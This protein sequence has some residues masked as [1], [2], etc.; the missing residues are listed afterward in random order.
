MIKASELRIGNYVKRS[1]D[2]L[3]I[4]ITQVDAIDF[5]ESLTGIPIT[6]EWLLKLGFTYQNDFDCVCWSVTSPNL[7]LQ[8]NQADYSEDKGKTWSHEFIFN[9]WNNL[10]DSKIMQTELKYI[11]QLQN[12]YFALTGEELMIIL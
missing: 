12:L 7:R 4:T 6:E 8:I 10:D 9:Y 11:H 3:I 1:V 2:G 5:Y